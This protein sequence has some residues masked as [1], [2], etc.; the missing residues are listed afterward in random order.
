MSEAPKP[1]A[2]A[3]PRAGGVLSL[4]IKEKAGLFAAYMPF[5][6]GGGI[7]IPT[8]KAYSVGDEVFMLLQLMDDP[9]R[10]AVSGKVVWITPNGAHGNRTQGIGVQFSANEAGQQARAKI[11]GILGGALQSSRTTHTM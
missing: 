4:S 9:A 11:E 5:V 1:A 7:F 2:P 8:A 10:I 6:T 3:A